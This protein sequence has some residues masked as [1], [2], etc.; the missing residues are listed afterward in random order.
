M[1]KDMFWRKIVADLLGEKPLRNSQVTTASQLVLFIYK[2]AL[3]VLAI[4]VTH[5]REDDLG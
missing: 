5:D 2:M 1:N 4:P 3:I